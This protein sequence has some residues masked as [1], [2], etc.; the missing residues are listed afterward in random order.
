MVRGGREGGMEFKRLVIDSVADSD[1]GSGA[2][3]TPGSG[4]G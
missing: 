2:V 4:M 1:P 3:L